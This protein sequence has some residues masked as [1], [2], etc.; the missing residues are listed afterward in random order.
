MKAIIVLAERQ[1]LEVNRLVKY[2]RDL[3]GTEVI[4]LPTKNET[5]H[6]P[7][8]NNYALREAADFMNGDPFF[9]LEPDSIPLKPNWLEG[10]ESEYIKAGKEF[11]L[12]SDSNPPHDMIGGIGVYG[13]STASVVPKNIEEHGWGWDTWMINNIPDQIHR[14]SLIQHSYG[15]YDEEGIASPHRFPRDQSIIRDESLVFHRDKYQDLIK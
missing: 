8:R 14:T 2:I 6:Y 10:I 1:L 13:P 3:D 9:W 11:M 5:D 15:I 4:V 7:A 12:S